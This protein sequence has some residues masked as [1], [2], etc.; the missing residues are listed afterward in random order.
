M[1]SGSRAVGTSLTCSSILVQ[2]TQILG[3]T[4][5]PS[6]PSRGPP[7]HPKAKPGWY[8]LPYLPA[9]PARVPHPSPAAHPFT[10]TFTRAVRCVDHSRKPHCTTAPPLAPHLQ[11]TAPCWTAPSRSTRR[12]RA[13]RTSTSASRTARSATSVRRWA[14]TARG[15]PTARSPRRTGAPCSYSPAAVMRPE[16]RAYCEA[17]RGR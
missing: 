4:P 13:T 7:L 5:T 6:L 9:H 11:Q 16:G 10:F 3:S 12:A 8:T 17:R 1:W 15:S 14:P 2:R